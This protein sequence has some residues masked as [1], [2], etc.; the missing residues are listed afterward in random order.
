[1]QDDYR[2]L[3]LLASC[4]VP[5]PVI[6][7]CLLRYTPREFAVVITAWMVVSVFVGVSFGHSVLNDR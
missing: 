3:G 2:L 1:M 5:L 4:A 6:A 7:A